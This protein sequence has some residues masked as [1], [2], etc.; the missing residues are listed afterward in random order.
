[1]RC[2]R[3]SPAGLP[4]LLLPGL[5]RLVATDNERAVAEPAPWD[6]RAVRRALRLRGVAG[7]LATDAIPARWRQGC[8]G[9]GG[10]PVMR[11]TK[12]H[13]LGN[14]YVYVNCFEERVADPVSLA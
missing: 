14:D 4:R 9:A 7:R 10:W 11:F 6:A 1:M 13:G 8:G 2:P 5:Q 12:M 3:V